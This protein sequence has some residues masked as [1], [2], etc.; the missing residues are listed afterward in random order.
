LRKPYPYLF[1]QFDKDLR[2]HY[3]PLDYKDQLYDEYEAV[4]Q[5]DDRSFSDYLTELRDYEAML[6]DV[7]IRD[8]FRILKKGINDDLKTAMIIFEGM[9]YEEFVQIAVRVDPALMKKRREK[10]RKRSTALAST[11]TTVSKGNRSSTL[12]STIQPSVSNRRFRPVSSS[13]RHPSARNPAVKELKPEISRQEADRRGLC[14]HCK[15]SGHMRRDCPKLQQQPAANVMSIVP[16][17]DLTDSFEQ[18]PLPVVNKLRQGYAIKDARSYKDAMLGKPKLEA[19]SWSVDKEKIP[20]ATDSAPS[21]TPSSL[22]RLEEPFIAR[23]RINNVEARCLIDTDASGDFVSSHFAFVNRLK[24]RKLGSAIPIQQAVK[25]S[26]PKCN[27]VATVTLKFGDWNKKTSMYVIH[28]ANYD[29]II[30]LPTLMD[31]GAKFD[32][33]SNTLHLQEYN[34]SLPL[35]RFQ[36]TNRMQRR[37]STSRASGA[38]TSVSESKLSAASATISPSIVDDSTPISAAPPVFSVYPDVDKHD[39]ADY[40]RNLI[41]EYYSDVFVDKLPA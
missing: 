10:Q 35:E 16:S 18:V 26:K 32:L 36:P 33:A 17:E 8:K 37:P 12:Q 38:T 34:V 28:L 6:D 5:G 25:G 39:T 2:A 20:I 13:K 30:G 41:Y 31:A 21:S 15:E 14:R 27:A 9:E 1:R 19:P 29:A 40:Y 3:V 24:H 7:S 11:S 22:P 23:I 4:V